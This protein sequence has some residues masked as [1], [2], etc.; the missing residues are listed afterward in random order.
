MIQNLLE[1]SKYAVLNT[2][3]HHAQLI[4][5]VSATAKNNKKLGAGW[6]GSGTATHNKRNGYMIDLFRHHTA[7]EGLWN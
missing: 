2:I 3:Q 6:F 1:M 5:L 4:I 7:Q